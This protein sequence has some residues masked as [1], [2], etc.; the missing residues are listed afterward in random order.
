TY[1]KKYPLSKPPPPN[2]LSRWNLARLG[3]DGSGPSDSFAGGLPR[4]LTGIDPQEA[5]MRVRAAMQRRSSNAVI[6]R[7]DPSLLL[8]TSV[9]LPLTAERSLRQILEFQLERL[10]PLPANEVYFEYRI[11]ARQP[12]AKTLTVELI[13]ATRASIDNAVALARSVGL[14]PRLT[15]APSGTAGSDTPIILWTVD[16]ATAESPRLRRL[17]RGLEVA[18]IVLALFAYGAYVYRLDELRDELRDEVALATKRSVAARDLV[19]Q[20]AQAEDA[21]ALLARRQKEPSPLLLLNELTKLVPETMWV[22]QLSV[23]KRNVEIIGYSPRVADL[24]SRVDDS[25]MF[26]NLKFR[27]PITLSPDGKGERFDVSFDIWVEETP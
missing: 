5:A 9:T 18:A 17:K 6:I 1:E 25:D 14:N 2:L 7:L 11:T 15:I 19:R 4:W 10:I 27:S 13:V 12:T 8:Q 26:Y 3:R 20:H 23:R 24:V 21:L 22:S 16:R